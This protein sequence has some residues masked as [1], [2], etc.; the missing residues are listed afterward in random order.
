MWLG[1]EFATGANVRTLS[2]AT[3]VEEEQTTIL[4]RSGSFLK[5]KLAKFPL[6]FA[7]HQFLVL[8]ENGH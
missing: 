8:A 6:F 1:S 7:Q 3:D 2:E 5:W 4:V